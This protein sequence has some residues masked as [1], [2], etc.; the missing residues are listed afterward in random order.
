MYVF[1]ALLQKGFKRLTAIQKT[2]QRK[3]KAERQG[4]EYKT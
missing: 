1:P 3:E 2:Q 4:E